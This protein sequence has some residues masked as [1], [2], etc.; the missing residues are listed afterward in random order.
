MR[1][2]DYKAN[3][4]VFAEVIEDYDNWEDD[5]LAFPRESLV[6]IKLLIGIDH[7]TNV[8]RGELMCIDNKVL[9]KIEALLE[10]TK[11]AIE[12]NNGMA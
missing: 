7:Y 6:R 9:Q 4:F 12:V 3:N 11:W 2:S 10:T 1:Y 8:E 5:I